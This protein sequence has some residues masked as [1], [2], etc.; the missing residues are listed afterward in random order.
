MRL[1]LVFEVFSSDSVKREV[2]VIGERTSDGKTVGI[3][4]KGRDGV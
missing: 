3:K 4:G 2:I 1:I